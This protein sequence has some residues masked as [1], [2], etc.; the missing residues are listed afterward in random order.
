[1]SSNGLDLSAYYEDAQLIAMVVAALRAVPHHK[2]QH[3]AL[4]ALA[5]VQQEP[6]PEQLSPHADGPYA[7]AQAALAAKPGMPIPDLAARV[8]G[9]DNDMNRK[10]IRSVLVGLKKQKRARQIGRGR[11]EAI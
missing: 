7:K 4:Q 11:W 6:Q 8:Y 1:M 9:T 5:L 2:R 3:V 10:R